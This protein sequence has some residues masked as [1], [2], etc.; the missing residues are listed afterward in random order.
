MKKPRI[1]YLTVAMAIQP[2]LAVCQPSLASKGNKHLPVD[3]AIK[4][5]IEQWMQ[6]NG[7]LS[8]LEN[9]GQMGDM[10]GKAV[11]SLL[12]RAS[13]G[14]VDM[15]VTTGGLSYVFTQKRC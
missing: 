1:F 9:K 6:D 12:F 4:G 5:K 13:G 14:G 7:G 2:I 8:F 3:D 11:K 15:Y 10:Q